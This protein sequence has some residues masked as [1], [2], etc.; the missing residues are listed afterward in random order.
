[1]CAL[2]TTPISYKEKSAAVD[3]MYAFVIA[4]FG[5]AYADVVLCRHLGGEFLR[6]FPHVEL[7]KIG[8]R[9][10]NYYLKLDNTTLFS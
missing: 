10:I 7:V 3:L 5:V 8:S 1:M 9:N 4:L 2:Q 6:L